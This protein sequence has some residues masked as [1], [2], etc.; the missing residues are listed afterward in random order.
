MISPQKITIVVTYSKSNIANPENELWP[1]RPRL[2]R[3]STA[4]WS[5]ELYLHWVALLYI[6][7][8]SGLNEPLVVGRTS[9]GAPVDL[10]VVLSAG[11]SLI[12]PPVL[13]TTCWAG[14]IM[15]IFRQ[16]TLS[17][18]FWF[19][20]YIFIYLYI[21]KKIWLLIKKI[22]HQLKRYSWGIFLHCMKGYKN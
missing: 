5:A 17:K 10:P 8:N 14:F 12:I 1:N 15:M 7:T 21:Y 3:I 6:A 22:K 13:H 11:L 19:G 16:A 2:M 9:A 20:A 4:A 18:S